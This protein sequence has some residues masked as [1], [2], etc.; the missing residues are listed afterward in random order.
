MKENWVILDINVAFFQKRNCKAK[1]P[2]LRYWCRD[3]QIVF[4]S[5]SFYNLDPDH[6]KPRP[7]K[8]WKPKKP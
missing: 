5:G 4:R 6:E 7:W 3:F 2:M 1:I 8:N